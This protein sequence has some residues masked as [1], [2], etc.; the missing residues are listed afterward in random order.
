MKEYP[1]AIIEKG[2][3][4]CPTCGTI[5]STNNRKNSCCK[6][7][8]QK[9]WQCLS[10]E[11]KKDFCKEPKKENNMKYA[12]V[13]FIIGLA[14][15]SNP[16]YRYFKFDIGCKSYLKSAADAP[17]IELAKMELDTALNYIR[18]NHLTNGYACLLIKNRQADLGCWYNR[19]N[20]AR[21]DLNMI[22]GDANALE[23]SNV[24]MKLRETLL[25]EGEVTVPS[26]VETYP[27]QWIITI[28]GLL[29]LA[30]CF[31]GGFGIMVFLGT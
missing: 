13:M 16:V 29:G 26:E 25:D 18:A 28:S 23:R 9:Y 20:S 6:S 4:K 10:N 15:I 27:Y 17:T 1:K 12:I 14:L 19:I 30:L 31:I 8:Y 24:L 21:L 7:A 3:L 2:V 5:L 11:L 22:D